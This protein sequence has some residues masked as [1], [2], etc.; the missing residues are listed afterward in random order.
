MRQ[1]RV[2]PVAMKLRAFDLQGLHLRLTDFDPCGILASIQRRLDTQ[3][4]RRRRGANK[5]NNHLATLQRLPTPIGGDM[6]EHAVLDFVPLAGPWRQVAD[7][8]AQATRI[9]KSL[10]FPLPQACTNAVTAT[11]IRCDQQL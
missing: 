11:T 7:P 5:A 9:G 4:L 3:A 2:V 6:A 8:D 1:N 10:Q